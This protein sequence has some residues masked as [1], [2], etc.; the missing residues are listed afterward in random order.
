MNAD[1]K[2]QIYHPGEV[3]PQSGIYEC[4]CGQSHEYSTDVKG[5]RF[6][7][8]QDGCSGSGWKLKT[9]AQPG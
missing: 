4:D 7:P 8:L 3:V 5:H 2:G 9:A 1:A 6:P